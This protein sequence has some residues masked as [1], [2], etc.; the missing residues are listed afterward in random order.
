MRHSITAYPE[1]S[2]VCVM[3]REGSGNFN[4][5]NSLKNQCAVVRVKRSGWG[6]TERGAVGQETGN[7][8][9]VRRVN[10]SGISERSA[11]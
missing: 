5:Y 4:S 7:I 9:T 2:D 1:R 8:N 3:D 6:R 11:Q 10:S